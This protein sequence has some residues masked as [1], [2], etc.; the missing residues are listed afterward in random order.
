[1]NQRATPRL[2]YVMTA[3]AAALWLVARF[4]GR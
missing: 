3:C 2:L 1:M 4:L